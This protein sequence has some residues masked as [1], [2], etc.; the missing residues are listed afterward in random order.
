[1]SETKWTPGE[2]AVEI[3]MMGH[4]GDDQWIT[5]SSGET[6]IATYKTTYVEY[7]EDAEN[8]ANARL[9]AAAPELYEAL[10]EARAYVPE[11]HGPITHKIN[12]ALAKAI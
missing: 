9:I 3:E 5:I 12:S 7:P 1:M 4:G 8:E 11:H 10:L 6:I 2:W